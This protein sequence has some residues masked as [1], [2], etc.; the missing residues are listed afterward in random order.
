[1]WVN[2]ELNA[3]DA[4]VAAW[5]PGSEG[6]G[7]AD[8]LFRGADGSV[9]YDFSGKLGFSWPQSAMPVS[10]EANGKVTGALFARG[11]GLS[12]AHGA[13]I[14]RLSEDPRIPPE[15]RTRDTL[16]HAAHVTAPWSIYLADSSAEV[17]LT[18]MR[19]QSPQRGLEVS[20]SS[21]GA[22]A[23]WDGSAPSWFRIAGRQA[24]FRGR[25][26]D[27]V[28]VE[29]R[30]R[31]EQR[32]TAAV[33][34]GLICMAPYQ[35][36]PVAAA[37]DGAAALQAASAAA[38]CGTDRGAMLDLTAPL[39]AAPLGRWQT[40]SFSLACFSA[41]GADLSN[42]EAPFAIATTGR[43]ALTINEVRLLPAKGAP[44]CGG[45]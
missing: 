26:A 5:Q 12:Y 34:A 30:Y 25:A 38:R 28:R 6:A 16:Y 14:A 33:R 20:Q 29:V 27:G 32:P 40:L 41:A 4:F 8:L 45:G 36:H 39:A 1:M 23:S 43:L 21:D 19:Q 37:V 13:H 44:H 22:R 10:F 18:T 31:L 17:R 15:R 9:P 7:I 24:D 2:P 35:R 11:Y 3:S 42:V